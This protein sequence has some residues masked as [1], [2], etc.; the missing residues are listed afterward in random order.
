MFD[1]DDKKLIQLEKDL[2]KFS[3]RAVPFANAAMLNKTAFETRKI[4]QHI[5]RNKMITRN[6]FTVASVRVNKAKPVPNINR[7]QSEVG[8]IAK[9]MA[10]QE[11]GAQKTAKGKQGTPI[12]TTTASGEGENAKKRRRLPKRVNK[13]AVIQLKNRGVKS[14][15]R[16]QKNFIRVQQ[17]LK[18]NDKFVYLET[19]RRKFIGRIVKKGKDAKVKMVWDLSRR[20]VVIPRNPWL[21]PAT[22]SASKKMPM[23]YRDA[24]KFQI[25]RQ[26]LFRSRR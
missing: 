8:S 1:F 23:F 6:K 17:A 18:N 3:D 5:I 14:K 7:Q 25:E 21:K 2:K 4:S 10:D 22:D 16:A 20:S 24:L 13:L 26:K 19:S 11:F 15:S 9:Y 12:A